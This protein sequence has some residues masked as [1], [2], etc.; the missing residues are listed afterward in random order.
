MLRVSVMRDKH[1]NILEY[2][3]DCSVPFIDIYCKCID[4]HEQLVYEY[5][6]FR[7]IR[8]SIFW[9]TLNC[10]LLYRFDNPIFPTQWKN[11]LIHSL[12]MILIVPIVNF[13]KCPF[14]CWRPCFYY[15]KRDNLKGLVLSLKRDWEMKRQEIIRKQV[16]FLVLVDIK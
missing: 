10:S 3:E 15:I 8:Y 4:I 7:L 2:S 12:T 9:R 6:L 1:C 11:L 14:N 13:H 16:C 5:L